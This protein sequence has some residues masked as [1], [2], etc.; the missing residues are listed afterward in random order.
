MFTYETGQLDKPRFVINFPTKGHWR[1]KSKLSDIE[2][3]LASLREVI[4]ER[5]ID[6]IAIPPLGCG[7]G[8]LD[9]SDV[10]PLIVEALEDLPGVRVM[11]YPPQEPPSAKSRPVRTRRPR[12][13][14]SRAALLAMLGTYV[15]LSQQEE[16]VTGDGASLLEI[17]KLMY[18]LQER[19]QP[20]RLDYVKGRY[21]PYAANLNHALEPLEGHYV[22]GYG[23]RSEYVLKLN[24]ISLIPGA[25]N[26]ATHWLEEHGDD[27]T[28]DRISAVAELLTGFAS[29]YGVELLATVHWTSTR[30]AAGGST[31]P[32]ALT[33]IIGNWNERKGRL[34]TEAHVGKAV[35]RLEELGWIGK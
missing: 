15:G 18:F 8:G 32:A 17:Q 12:M 14:V 24:P 21:G 7:N 16:A 35:G 9:W 29:V 1:S 11:V 31:D 22:R 28:L 4:R 2:T 3:G 34:F 23:D 6:S 27:M 10:R 26:E 19:G 30:E 33:E 25:D 13:T 5:H 20:L